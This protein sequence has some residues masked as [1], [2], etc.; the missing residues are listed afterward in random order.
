MLRGCCRTAAA[1][2]CFSSEPIVPLENRADEAVT[3]RR[4]IKD[5]PSFHDFVAS[6]EAVEK[7]NVKLKLEEG[8]KRL[9][10]P[11]WL[12]KEQVRPSMN[13]NV[14]R[15]K[16]QLKGLRLATVCEEAR[17]P[18]LGE[19]WGGGQEEGSLSTA[20]I[21]LMG[22]TCT[23]GCR[24]CSVKTARR[25]PPLDP[26][27]P[28]N[29]A[30]AVASWGVDYI[31]ITSVDRDDVP[32]GG[33]SHFAETVKKLKQMKPE[34]LV[35]CLL[36]DFDGNQQSIQLMARSGLDV[37]AHNIETVERLTPWVRDPRA[38]YRQS[39]AALKLA[40]DTSSAVIT[41]TSI[42][43][44][45][46]ESDDEIKQTL[47]DLRSNEVDVITFGQY[48]QPTKRHLLVKEWVTPQ[49]F[50]EWATYAKS[51][52]FLYVASGPLMS[53]A[54]TVSLDREVAI[55]L[56]GETIQVEIE[57]KNT[58]AK[59]KES[60]AWGS[61]QLTC[62]RTIGAQSALPDRPTTAMARNASTVFSSRPVV[63]FCD[64]Q[65]RAGESRSFSCEI[66]LPTHGIPPTFRGQMVKYLNRIAIGMQHVKDPIKLAYIP[67]RILPSVGLE[68]K[69]VKPLNPFLAESSPQ[70]T[71]CQLVVSAVDEMTAP[72]KPSIF[73]MTNTLGKV[74]TLS[75]PKKAFRLGEDIVGSLDFQNAAVTCVQYSV[76]LE[77]EEKLIEES[78]REKEKSKTSG[79][80]NIVVYG[81]DHKV[82]A[83]IKNT[84]FRIPI[85]MQLPPTF[86]TDIVHL[87]WK[88]RF[89]FVT[90]TADNSEIFP[91]SVDSSQTQAPKE[92]AIET[93]NWET[94]IF[95]LPCSPANAALTDHLHSAQTQITV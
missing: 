62:E 58:A 93:L 15:L 72:R 80:K 19:C 25:P 54:V 53:I 6:D 34:L 87:K 79:R 14:A 7:Y 90:T 39:L 22:D 32:D 66:P 61:V 9:R 11:P 23:R 26:M 91:L 70:P 13:D 16:K 95:V 31:V 94:D 89:E 20:T 75:L 84:G 4:V 21:M 18:N 65:L 81:T 36:P 68:A 17:C 55:Y 30:R 46:G 37:Y 33:A 1:T 50:D 2:R 38:K 83:F 35:E 51:L 77:T 42:M 76:N 43:L 60:L 82:C 52:G 64:L 85:P 69:A 56:M 71:V 78:N 3:K 29:T 67:I 63:L 73:N 5:G 45:L 74:T 49:K 24:F 47:D 10:L 12:K 8:D 92:V 40:K 41:K 86:H 88:L 57:L 27:E 44:G 28:E 48:M 59:G